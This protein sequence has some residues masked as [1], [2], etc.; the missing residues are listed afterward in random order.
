VNVRSNTAFHNFT[1]ALISWC[2]RDSAH[3]HLASSLRGKKTII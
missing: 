3:D 2:G 1:K